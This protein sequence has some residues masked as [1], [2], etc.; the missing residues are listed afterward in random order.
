MRI[1]L[2]LMYIHIYIYMCVHTRLFMYFTQ[3][4]QIAMML[5]YIL[6]C[7]R[8]SGQFFGFRVIPIPLSGI[9]TYSIP[10]NLTLKNTTFFNG[11][12]ALHL[13]PWAIHERVMALLGPQPDHLTSVIPALALW[14]QIWVYMGMISMN[15]DNYTL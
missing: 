7:G 1:N 4:C 15:R 9:H 13:F 11:T 12:S 14:R 10:S 5:D 2:L 8:Y 3:S 6:M